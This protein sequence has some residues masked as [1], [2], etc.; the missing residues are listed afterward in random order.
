ML[1]ITHCLNIFYTGPKLAHQNYV[2]SRKLIRVSFV[3]LMTRAC[4][5]RPMGTSYSAS[6][7]CGT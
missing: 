5:G 1:G 4:G 7:D 6:T 2:P 3:L